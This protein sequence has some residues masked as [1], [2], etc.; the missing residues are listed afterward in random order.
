MCVCVCVYGERNRQTATRLLC[1]WNAPGKNTGVG[2]PFPS[3]GDLPKPGTK[4]IS[5]ALQAD[6]LPSEP[7]R[8]P[9]WQYF[10]KLIY[11]FSTISSKIPVDIVSEADPKMLMK[12]QRIFKK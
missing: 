11:I 2:K 6:S 1:P 5:P 3:S 9:W 8:K 10:P 7:P 4:S 12:M